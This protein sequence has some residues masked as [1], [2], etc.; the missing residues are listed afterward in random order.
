MHA[1]MK[2]EAESGTGAAVCVSQESHE[3]QQIVDKS[4]SKNIT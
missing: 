1:V 3:N 2:Y 4:S